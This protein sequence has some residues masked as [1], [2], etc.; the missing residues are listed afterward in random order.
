[1]SPLHG[2]CVQSLDWELRSCMPHGEAKKKQN[3]TVLVPQ[4]ASKSDNIQPSCGCHVAI[5]RTAYLTGISASIFHNYDL[6]HLSLF[7]LRILNLENDNGKYMKQLQI[8]F[9]GFML[10]TKVSFI[11]KGFKLC[12]PSD[13]PSTVHSQKTNKKTKKTPHRTT[14]DCF[15]HKKFPSTLSSARQSPFLMYSTRVVS[16]LLSQR[17]HS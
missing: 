3:K 9:F 10:T 2:A 15:Q 6:E 4:D 17:S 1:M 5:F 14:W 7:T 13:A 12:S 11:P 8:A 16:Q